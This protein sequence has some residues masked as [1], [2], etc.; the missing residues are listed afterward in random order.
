MVYFLDSLRRHIRG[1]S[2]KMGVARTDNPGIGAIWDKG[3]AQPEGQDSW[4]V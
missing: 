4:E 2:K 3:L 1:E